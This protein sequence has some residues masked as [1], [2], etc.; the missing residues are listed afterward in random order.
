MCVGIGSGGGGGGGWG[1][2]GEKVTL[3]SIVEIMLFEPLRKLNVTTVD[4]YLHLY[5]TSSVNAS[6]P[7]QHTTEAQ[8][9]PSK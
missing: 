8:M 5:I 1:T 4:S 9:A 6:C 3:L 7:A 2:K